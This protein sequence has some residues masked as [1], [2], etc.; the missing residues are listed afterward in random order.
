MIAIYMA[1]IAALVIIVSLFTAPV[2]I[3]DSLVALS[4][5]MES[6]GDEP[7]AEEHFDL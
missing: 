5:H 6:L 1:I 7:D 4:S 2:Q 3:D